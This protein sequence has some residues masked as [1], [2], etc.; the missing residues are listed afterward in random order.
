MIR[1]SKLSHKMKK[2][3]NEISKKKGKK[4]YFKGKRGYIR[5]KGKKIRVI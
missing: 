3:I 2:E 5:H 1:F 4:I